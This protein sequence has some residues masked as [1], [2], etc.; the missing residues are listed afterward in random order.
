MFV[1]VFLHF[2][3]ISFPFEIDIIP[4]NT[5][6]WLQSPIRVEYKLYQS[7][8]ATAAS[9][10][11]LSDTLMPSNCLWRPLPVCCLSR[12]PA[13]PHPS[14]F[15]ATLPL[16]SS[17]APCPHYCSVGFLSHLSARL[18]SCGL[19]TSKMSRID[20][21]TGVWLSPRCASVM[22]NVHT[23]SMCALY[24]CCCFVQ[25][26][27]RFFFLRFNHFLYLTSDLPGSFLQSGWIGAFGRLNAK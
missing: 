20:C 2:Y 16:H 11:S 23:S 5:G 19:H 27:V 21:A 15:Q 10:K 25:Y 13:P 3:C 18:P 14:P 4:L 7:A 1:F 17:S 6:E 24:F 22:D 9:D 12:T 8:T 26:F